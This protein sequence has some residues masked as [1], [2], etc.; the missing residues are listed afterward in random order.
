MCTLF[1]VLKSGKQILQK[2]N[3]MF[4]IQMRKKNNI[5]YGVEEG[6]FLFGILAEDIES[7][8]YKC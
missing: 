1:N 8:I 6:Y 3:S 2:M 5:G 4:P 7:P